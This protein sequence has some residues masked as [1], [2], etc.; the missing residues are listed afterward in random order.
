MCQ[1]VGFV[2]VY[3]EIINSVGA[4][5]F[6]IL[7][8]VRIVRKIYPWINWIFNKDLLNP[9]LVFKEPSIFFILVHD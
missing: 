5:Q 3:A 8:S 6:C 9:H 4:V 2:I 7:H 1:V